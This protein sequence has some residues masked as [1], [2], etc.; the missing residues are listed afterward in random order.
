[1]HSY[2]QQHLEASNYVVVVMKCDADV[3]FKGKQSLRRCQSIRNP[4]MV[5]GLLYFLSYLSTPAANSRVSIQTCIEFLHL[6]I[7]IYSLYGALLQ[8][9]QDS[10][11]LGLHIMF[12]VQL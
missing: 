9:F 4:D 6:G 12:S 3:D 2:Y 11:G 7:Y 10:E 8:S 5:T 1:M